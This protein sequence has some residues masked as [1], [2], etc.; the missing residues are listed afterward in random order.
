MG[1]NFFSLPL[2]WRAA[3]SSSSAATAFSR[4]RSRKC[5]GDWRIYRDSLKLAAFVALPASL[6]FLCLP[7]A[8]AH[9]VS[10]GEMSSP[11]DW[12]SSLRGRQSWTRHH[13]RGNPDC[14][15]LSRIRMP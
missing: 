4:L 9:F 3:G 8:L 14:R 6:T 10:F 7:T 12:L 5:H 11:A 2:R 15:D 13:R 1:L